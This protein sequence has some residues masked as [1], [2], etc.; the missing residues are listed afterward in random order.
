MILAS[1]KYTFN[2]PRTTADETHTWED[3]LRELCETCLHAWV[4]IDKPD[5][6]LE[7]VL[8]CFNKMTFI[9]LLWCLDPFGFKR[10]SHISS[11]YNIWR[12]C[13]VTCF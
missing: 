8:N 11:T 7:E 6:L 10:S 5:D 1:V 4:S 9:A 13:E 3:M 2:G 12:A